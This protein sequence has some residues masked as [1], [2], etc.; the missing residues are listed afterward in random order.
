LIHNPGPRQKHRIDKDKKVTLQ[1]ENSSGTAVFTANFDGTDGSN[2]Y[3]YVYPG[4]NNSSKELS[5]GTYTFVLTG[6]T[7][8]GA[9]ASAQE[10]LTITP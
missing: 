9:T 10:N 6:T 5:A 2:T 8:G 1:L 3:T 4:V 7:S